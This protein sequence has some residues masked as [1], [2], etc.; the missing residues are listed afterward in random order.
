MVKLFPISIVCTLFLLH[1]VN[2][3]SFQIDAEGDARYMNAELKEHEV[4]L[5]RL[6]LGFRHIISDKKGDRLLLFCRLES[7]HNF[8]NFLVE[9]IYALYKGSMGKWNIMA[10]KFLIPFGLN[11]QYVT[12]S[13][14]VESLEEKTINNKSDSGLQFLGQVGN[15]DYALSVTQG[16][17]SKHWIDNDYGKIVSFRAGF[18]GDEFEDFNFG[19]SGI[20]GSVFVD[21]HK[22]FKNLIAFDGTKYY[23]LFIFRGEFVFGLENESTVY[24]LF[25]SMDYRFFPSVDLSITYN[26]FMK[27][28]L[29]MSATVGLTY[30]TPFFG[31]VIR[32][33]H[34]ITFGEWHNESFI[35]IYN[36]YSFIF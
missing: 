8:S 21:D 28:T 2:V 4:E 17:E 7:E 31:F 35:Q 29:N 24:G 23:Y 20:I 27:V 33:A 19:L 3:Y 10:G 6:G 12:E 16:I 25:L 5:H 13:L 26:L 14:L 34:R 30:H 15:F 32:A 9:Q 22:L 11:V 18:S 1:A 36:K